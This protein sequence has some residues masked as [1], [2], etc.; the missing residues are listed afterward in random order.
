ME[1]EMLESMNG[2]GEREQNRNGRKR[3]SG[4]QRSGAGNSSR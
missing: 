4:A 2:R 3:M 1:Q